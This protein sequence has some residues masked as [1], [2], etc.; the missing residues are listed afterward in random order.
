MNEKTMRDFWNEQA[1]WSRKTFGSDDERGPVGPLKHL[2]KE[3]QEC[4]D[5]PTDDMEYVDMV[6]LIF[7]A[8]RRK[9]FTFSTLTKKCFEKLE[10]N[11]QRQWN[12]PTSDA[13]VEHIR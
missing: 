9:G 5:N 8:A 10:I 3:I 2:Q 1:V 11:K 13:P 12:K 6:F 4:L 7:D